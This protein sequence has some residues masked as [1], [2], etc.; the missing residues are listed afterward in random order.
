M[1]SLR[2][3]RDL[4]GTLALISYL[5]L[6]SSSARAWDAASD[7]RRRQ[8]T[9][10]E[11]N[12]NAAQAAQRASQPMFGGGRYTPMSSSRTTSSSSYS[13]SR[14]PSSSYNTLDAIAE[15]LERYQQRQQQPTHVVTYTVTRKESP[16][17]L[18]ARIRA[19]AERGDVFMQWT[20]GR[21]YNS[22]VGVSA[23]AAE[24]V[25]WFRAAAERGNEEGQASLGDMYYAGSGVPKDHG[26]AVSWWVKAAQQGHAV[27]AKNAGA[28]Y[29]NGWGVPKSVERAREMY[30]IAAATREP[31]ASLWLAELY[32]DGAF[33]APDMTAACPLFKIA[34]EQGL[35]YAMDS[36][37]GCFNNDTTLV[38]IRKAADGG[39]P[40]ARFK[41]GMAM[42]NGLGMPKDQAGG[43]KLIIDSAPAV[44]EDT[45]P[46]LIAGTL[47][48]NGV[49]VKKN[50]VEAVRF[51][52]MAA[53]RK[54]PKGQQAL[55]EVAQKA[56][57]GK[58]GFTEANQAFD[59]LQGKGVPK[60]EAK[61]FARMKEA[62]EA[63]S[64]GA[65]GV[66]AHLYHQGVG[67]KADPAMAAYYWHTAA[68]LGVPA[69]KRDWGVIHCVADGVAKDESECLKW[70]REAADD[71]DPESLYRMGKVHEEG[72]VGQ[73]K[74]LAK[75][76]AAYKQAADAGFEPAK[77]ALDKLPK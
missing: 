4:L 24:A 31:E 42:L 10:N 50:I 70:L 38:W 58:F 56:R 44:E 60:D 9:I 73:P 35:L 76:R 23:N 3:R 36:Y 51:Y 26:Q 57:D 54:D 55:G 22:G 18:A 67:T 32:R 2:T 52:R 25:R 20:L 17:Q 66:L 71:G 41:L 47:Y 37:A 45:K 65:I 40:R 59:F 68:L 12:R 34:A 33:G 21:M 14:S 63:G 8:M 75:A 39:L 62:A 29:Q 43:A 1:I 46:L 69:A 30:K 7:E 53:E 61:G 15:S 19:S 72:D 16:Q 28:S 77:Q 13:S 6:F 27:A 48:F 64:P 5:S 11:M 49:G 74:D